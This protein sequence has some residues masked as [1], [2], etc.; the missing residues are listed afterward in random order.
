MKDE[1][2]HRHLVDFVGFSFF[3]GKTSDHDIELLVE[4]EANL[5]KDILQVDMIDDYYQ[6]GKKDGLL[7]NWID[8]CCSGVDFVLKVDDDVYLNVRNLA[9]TGNLFPARG[10]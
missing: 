10:K 8:R 3:L 2:F 9:T 4:K 6:V 1:H 7:F 5:H